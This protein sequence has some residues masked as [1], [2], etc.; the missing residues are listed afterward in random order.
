M[1]TKYR[2]HHPKSSIERFHLSRKKGGRGYTDIR[3]IH[4]KQITTLRAYFYEKAEEHEIHRTIVKADN[5]LTPL[6]LSNTEY[7]P[8]TYLNTEEDKMEHWMK[9][10]LHG[11]YPAILLQDHIDY[12]ASCKWL[13]SG[14]I[15]SET[16]GYIVAIQ[17]QVI[18]TRNYQ[19]YIIKDS[20]VLTDKCRMCHNNT[21]NIDH[22]ISGCSTLAP[23][24]YTSRHN[25]IA[26]IVHQQ[27]CYNYGIIKH[28]TPYYKYTPQTVIETST[29]KVY[30]NRQIITD[31]AIQHNK[32]DIVLTDKLKSTTYIIDIAVPM[33][34]NITKKYSEK[35]N[36]YLPLAD[37]IK[38]MWRQEKVLIIPLIIG[39][40]GEI[41]KSLL[42]NLD[43][44]N[45]QKDIYILMQKA[46]ILE[47][48]SIVRRVISSEN[49]IK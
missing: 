12:N 26:N 9:K 24:Q 35:I 16:E 41:P 48:C 25:K 29:C 30:W 5:K 17:D 23:K 31:A 21:E 2:T 11:R 13:C 45:L 38:E 47:T 18:P 28:T 36:K 43:V 4:Y 10:E 22:V 3:N 46:A 49:H 44:L 34:S 37:E 19:K 42:K 6:N 1:C 15:F 33:A 40:T 20:A 32:P 39:A 14:N 8:L 7:N 27:I